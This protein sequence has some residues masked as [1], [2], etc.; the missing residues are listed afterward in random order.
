V[1]K[2]SDGY[3]NGWAFEVEGYAD[4]HTAA[5]RDVRKNIERFGK[6]RTAAYLKDLWGQGK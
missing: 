3:G 2:E 1:S 6:E 5:D 4:G